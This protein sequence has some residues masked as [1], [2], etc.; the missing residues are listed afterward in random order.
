M[1]KRIN[2]PLP[3][4]YSLFFSKTPAVNNLNCLED[5]SEQCSSNS[6]PALII[7]IVLLLFNTKKPL[8]AST[9][10]N[11]DSNLEACNDNYYE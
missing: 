4:P 2:K 8:K 5:S 3:Y 7:L 11:T 10:S 9:F 1:T 6:S